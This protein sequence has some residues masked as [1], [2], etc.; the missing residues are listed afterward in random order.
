MASELTLANRWNAYR[1]TK[2]VVFWTGAA[3]A[4]LTMI[5]GFGWGGW[6]TGRTAAGMAEGAAGKARSELAAS[7]CV[8]RFMGA[9][10]AGAKLAELKTINSWQ[11]N[12]FVEKGGWVTLAVADGPV[13]GA[14]DICGSK[15]AEMAPPEQAA[16][17][18]PA[19]LR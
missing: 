12:D 18:K 4:V 6:V 15:L 1:P 13:R 2:T 16:I 11:R 7:I 5:V 9:T 17:G 10:N 8:E 14:A 3:C 19:T